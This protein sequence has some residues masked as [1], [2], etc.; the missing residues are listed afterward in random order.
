MAGQT[1]SLK[2][3]YPTGTDR[4]A[5]GDNAMQ[6]LA[7]RIEARM[8]W[9]VLGR[10]ASAAPNNGIAG[11]API[12]ALSLPV[13]VGAGRVI[14]IWAALSNIVPSAA[15]IAAVGYLLQDGAKVQQ[16]VQYFANA[17]Y[18]L[19]VYLTAMLTPSTG[20]HTYAVNLAAVG[21]TVNSSPS[22]AAPNYMVVQDIGPQV[23][24]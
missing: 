16:W 5:D 17:T 2:I 9:G 24:T 7:E 20:A 14:H 6:A 4:V 10:A 15:G 1:T 13:T 19:P 8:P 22:A 21:G 18:G 12:T 3:P 23:I 11:E